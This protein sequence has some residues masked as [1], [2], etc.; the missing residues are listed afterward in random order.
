MKNPNTVQKIFSPDLA[1]LG[2][3]LQTA[4]SHFEHR[5]SSKLAVTK[6]PV[7]SQWMEMSGGK[8]TSTSSCCNAVH[9]HLKCSLNS[10]K[11]SCFHQNVTQFHPTNWQQIDQMSPCYEEWRPQVSPRP[12]IRLRIPISPPFPPDK[13]TF[14]CYP[15]IP[16]LWRFYLGENLAV[17]TNWKYIFSPPDSQTLF[18]HPLP[19]FHKQQRKSLQAFLN[20]ADLISC[21]EE[22]FPVP[23]IKFNAR[24]RRLLPPSA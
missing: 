10:T 13:S 4:A 14:D 19:L 7:W 18:H 11:S 2:H 8:S 24:T 9:P 5:I 12:E 21:V 1:L 23:F 20:P 16:G 17:G 22:V 6:H 15:V 3:M